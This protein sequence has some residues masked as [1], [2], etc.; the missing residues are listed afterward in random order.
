MCKQILQNLCNSSAMKY[1]A[2]CVWV[3]AHKTRAAEYFMSGAPSSDIKDEPQSGVGCV[4]DA[5]MND[6]G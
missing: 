2:D 1:S 3:L 5:F 4:A 6:E